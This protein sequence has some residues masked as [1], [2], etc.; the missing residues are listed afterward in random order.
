MKKR[1][2]LAATLM[3]LS[4]F[5]AQSL[6]VADGIH[7]RGCRAGKPNPQFVHRRSSLLQNG[8]NPMIGNRRQLVVLASFQ[9]QDFAQDHESALAT[10]D[11]V[12]NAENFSDDKYVGSLHDYFLAQS[13]G[14]FNL[15]F[16]LVFVELP[17]ERR[18]YRSTSIDDENSQYMVDDIVDKLMKQDIDWSKYDWDGDSFVNQLIILYAGKG[19]NA[20]GGSNSIWPH[21][22]W[23]SQHLDQETDDPNDFRSYRT[24][25]SGDQEYHIDCYCCVQEIVHYGGT[26]TPFGTLCHEYSHCFGLPDFYYGTSSVVSSWDLMDA[27]IFNEKGF[28]PCGYS[29]HERM[30]MG[31]LTPVELTSTIHITNMPALC[32]EPQAYL[33]RNDG[34]ENEY[35]IVENRQRKGWDK[36]LPGSGIVVF[37]VDYDKQ[38]WEGSDEYP[39]SALK[40]RYSIFH[41]NNA[42]SSHFDGWAYPYIDNKGDAPMV[43]D[44]LTNTSK[45]AATLNNP[46]LDGELL[47]SKPITEM[48]VHA[49]GLAS[50]VFM[51]QVDTAIDAPSVQGSPNQS[52]DPEW[53]AIDGRKLSGKPTQKGIYIVEG[54]KVIIP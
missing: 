34:A 52:S 49:D 5:V 40:T 12:F 46:N 45:P 37:H 6:S 23:L 2:V 19:M 18:K 30:M 32:D 13:Y 11:Q 28:R 41:A 51:N 42:G 3:F 44:E 36:E 21:Q 50:F 16:D 29:A 8:E 33:I 48:S 17:N 25:T 14:Q 38:I 47:M 35:Y 10:W 4:T 7:Q 15:T 43:N 9:D 24:V 26:E 1:M 20:G 27:G 31:W 53:Y 54:K 22:W 39:N